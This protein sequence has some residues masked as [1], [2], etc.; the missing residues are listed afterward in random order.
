[1]LALAFTI[2]PIPSRS[3]RYALSTFPMSHLTPLQTDFGSLPPLVAPF[4]VDGRLNKLGLRDLVDFVA[5]NCA[6]GLRDA[7]RTGEFMKWTR[8]AWERVVGTCANQ[9][10]GRVPMRAGITDM[11]EG[12]AFRALNNP[13][14]ALPLAAF[15]RR[16]AFTTS[17]LASRWR[18]RLPV[19]EPH[20]P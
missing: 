6:D 18:S 9:N 10:R 20:S 16:G 17:G 4:R 19:G 7:S 8:A 15:G 14:A 11:A 1:M 2:V 12:L 13:T 5:A 3:V